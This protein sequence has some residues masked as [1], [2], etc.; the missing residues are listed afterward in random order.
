[1]KAAIR[2]LWPQ[3]PKL[4]PLGAKELPAEGVTILVADDPN[5]GR[6]YK[7]TGWLDCGRQ[8]FALLDIGDGLRYVVASERLRVKAA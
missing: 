7:L 4:R 2:S 6:E 1:M 3:P 8:R 5:T